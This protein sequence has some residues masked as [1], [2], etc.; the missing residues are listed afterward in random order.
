[1]RCGK[2]PLKIMCCLQICKSFTEFNVNY[3]Y[4]S[5]KQIVTKM[6]LINKMSKVV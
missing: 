6:K 1:M 2:K 3:S 5:S 4:L